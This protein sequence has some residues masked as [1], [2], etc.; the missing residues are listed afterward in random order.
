MKTKTTV[1]AL[2]LIFTFFSFGQNFKY[3]Q[4]E[5]A[6]QT[7]YSYAGAPTYYYDVPPGATDYSND[8][9][10][11]TILTGNSV[12]AY[13]HIE[14]LPN[15][16]PNGYA[17][18]TLVVCDNCN[19]TQ[20]AADLEAYSSVIRKA[21]PLDDRVS[22]NHLYVKILDIA[23]GTPT[24]SSAGII[25][26][27]DPELNTIFNTYNVYLYAQA[28]PSSSS[29]SLLRTYSLMCDCNGGDLKAA[30]DAHTT[31]IEVTERIALDSQLLSTPAVAFSDVQ[32]Y[33]NPVENILHISNTTN[34]KS[35]EVFSIQGQL[36]LTQKSQ[37]ATVAMSQLQSGLYFVKLT[38]AANN[39]STFKILKK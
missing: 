3:I 8:A 26:T 14:S 13:D 2:L 4:I 23:V 37:F 7:P 10:L 32:L 11:N 19:N 27:N 34:I 17:N 5:M 22:Q 31:V 36:M 28:F 1:T 38:D 12:I 30:L 6:D 29:N 18:W 9:G 15:V 21:Y 25:T 39:S 24:G 33:P 35:L 16:S 20:L